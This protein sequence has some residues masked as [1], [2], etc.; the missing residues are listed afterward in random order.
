MVIAVLQSTKSTVLQAARFGCVNHKYIAK[1]AEGM[2]PEF[3]IAQ[4]IP[5]AKLWFAQLCVALLFALSFT[6]VYICL[7]SS[8]E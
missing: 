4:N 8:A 2:Q 6:S 5:F 3:Q 1:G 7:V